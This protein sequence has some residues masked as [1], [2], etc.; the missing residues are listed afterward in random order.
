MKRPCSFFATITRSSKTCSGNA[1]FI[2]NSSSSST[3]EPARRSRITPSLCCRI[4]SSVPGISSSYL[5]PAPF[6]HQTK[7]L[8]VICRHWAPDL[9]RTEDGAGQMPSWISSRSRAAFGLPGTARGRQNEENLVAH[10]PHDERW[11]SAASGSTEAVIHRLLI[12][13][14]LAS[15]TAAFRCPWRRHIST[16]RQPPSNG[17]LG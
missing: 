5:S 9:V 11:R 4:T 2:S 12:L 17:L 15:T 6:I 3:T 13:A 8:D 16:E 7:P 10:L 14:L 1:K